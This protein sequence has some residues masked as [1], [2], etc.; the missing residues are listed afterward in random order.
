MQDKNKICDDVV[1]QLLKGATSFVWKKWVKYDEV[2]P[3][4]DLTM[5]RFPYG[6]EIVCITT[7]F[8]KF[9]RH[10]EKLRPRVTLFGTSLSSGHFRKHETKLG[11]IP[12]SILDSSGL[13]KQSF[14]F[15]RPKCRII[16]QLHLT[17]FYVVFPCQAVTKSIITLT[18]HS[19][20]TYP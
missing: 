9:H 6:C 12:S 11:R 20:N 1:M 5:A 4:E 14:I 8:L 19:L 2:S 15:T 7:N 17:N 16:S 3:T 10:W 18:L 13:F